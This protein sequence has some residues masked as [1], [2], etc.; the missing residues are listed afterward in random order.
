MPYTEAVP[1]GVRVAGDI[2]HRPD[3]PS[4]YRARVR[5]FDPAS[6][7]R[8]SL[9]EGKDTH[10]EAE[11]WI[12]GI[13]KAAE[14]GIAPNVATMSLAEYG[15]SN[16]DLALRGLELKTLDPYLAGWRR[17]VVPALGHFPVRMIS[18]GVVDRTVHGWIAD[19]QSRSTVK[20]SLA[21]LVRVMEQAVRDGLI[22]VNPAR[23]TGWQREYKQAEDELDNP[24]A[25][26]L[27]DWPTLLR[28]AQ[29]LVERSHGHYQ[30]WGE[31]V[32]FAA[33]TA[34]RIGEVSGVRVADIDTVNWIWTVRRQ[35]TPAP[36][37]LIDKNTKGKRA[38]HVPI[39]EEIRPLVAARILAAGPNPDARPHSASNTCAATTYA[40][41]DSP[42]SPTQESPAHVLRK[43]AGHGSLLTTQRYLHPDMSQ[44]T[45]AGTALTAH[46]NP[47]RAPLS[48]AVQPVPG[49][50]RWT[51]RSPSGP[52][53]IRKGGTGFLRYRLRPA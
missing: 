36:G 40:T 33:A 45:G 19:E 51:T 22:A 3:R 24:R 9:S 20:N 10:D 53:D 29:A 2:E 18:N 41:P 52:Q 39:V 11:D 14:A 23:V 30:G 34:A 1:L 49:R 43:I 50:R 42:G 21:V 17:R 38:R 27:R 6:K 8:R 7:R 5:W 28:L 47:V 48:L 16:M 4:P 15:A 26:A 37:G 32:L 35:T 12:S 31:V 13:L 44:I 46:L 25:L